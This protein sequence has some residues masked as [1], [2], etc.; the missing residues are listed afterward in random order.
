[1][2]I[3]T[4]KELSENSRALWLKAMHAVELRNYGYAI[5]LIQN[6]LKDAPGFLDARKRLRDVEIIATKGK[7]SF[8]S[9][10]STAS[11]KGAGMV[12]KDPA[13]AMELAEKNLESDPL[14]VQINHLLKDA[15][16]AAGLPEIAA[17]A[18]ETIIRGNPTDTKTMHE[19]GEH[20]LTMGRPDDAVAIYSKIAEINPGDLTAVKRSKDAAATA[21]MKKGGWDTAQSY[22]DLMKN[23]DEAISLEQKGRVVKSVDM[24][25]EQLA[26]LTPQWE[27][28][29][30]NVD[31]T[32]RIAKLWEDR[33]EQQ[34]DDESLNGTVYYYHHAN[35]LV[36]GSDPAVARKLSNLNLQRIELRIKSI[37]DWLGGGGETH[38]EADAHRDELA[39]LKKHKAELLVSEAKKRVERN[40]T[41]LQLRFE[42]GEQLVRAGQY[43]EAIQELQR[44]KQNPNARLKA[45]NLLGQCYTEKNMLDLAVKQFQEAAA[46]ILAMDATKKEILYKLGL[47]FERMGKKDDSLKCMKDIY[48]V[49]Y[50]YM[51]VAQR[52]EQS[53]GS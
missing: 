19:L 3:T 37:E 51:D 25:D 11:L 16:K 41:D 32:K 14:N 40:P 48:E 20:Y 18:L 9:G 53:Y 23:K 43:T 21:S 15:S 36:S 47:V 7:K 31:L 6:I 22:R 2:P 12:K 30:D 24:I 34:Q 35:E 45:M 4:E 39:D 17:F 42:L 26:E 52:V 10:L 46:E 27:T 28:A 49:D 33:F 5:S 8:L 29:Q 50:G 44:A 38:D 1:M 13:A